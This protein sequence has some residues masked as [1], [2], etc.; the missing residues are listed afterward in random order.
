MA[1]KT[2]ISSGPTCRLALALLVLVLIFV[3]PPATR[4]EA[5]TAFT[6]RTWTIH[7]TAY[8]GGDRQATVLLPSWYGPTDNPS[9]PLVIAP[10]GRG[11]NGRA[12][13]KYWGNL[14][15]R[16]GF[17]VVNPDGMG[18]RMGNYSYGFKGQIDDLARMPEL[19]MRALPWLHVDLSRIYALGS[20]MGGQETLL[21]VARHPGLLAGAAAMDSVT[22]LGKRYGEL[23]S[24]ACNRR[25]VHR[26]GEPYGYV[27]QANMRREVGGAPS[28]AAAAYAARSPMHFARRI[29]SSGVPLQIWW[30]R[31][32]RIVTDQRGQSGR[33]F[34]MLTTLN[35]EAPIVGYEGS[36]AHSTEMHAEALLPVAVA[37]FGLVS[38][39][40]AA[41]VA[42][43]QHAPMRMPAAMTAAAH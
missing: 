27:L 34:R 14:P 37:G 4:V 28:D 12:N 41:G 43:R 7:Y 2:H 18:R 8:N 38:R 11:C 16:G 39:T 6:V 9:I 30:S 17:A 22:D 3:L 36:W 31:N 40:Y 33:L 29:A 21:L 13:A 1:T 5:Q 10:H 20:S 42:E 23:P 25:C 15:A 26:F 24:V 32:D 35:P 19:A